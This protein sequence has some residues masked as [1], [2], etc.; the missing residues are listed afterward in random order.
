MAQGTD[1]LNERLDFIGIDKAARDRMRSLQPIIAAVI[2]DAMAKFYDKVRATPQTSQ[3]FSNEGQMRGAKARQESHWDVI[4]KAEYDASYVDGVN[5]VGRAHARLGLE[6]RWYIGGYALV[7]EDLIASIVRERWPSRFGRSGRAP[8]AAD[9]AVVVKAALLDMDYA[10][11]VYLETLANERKA[12]EEARLKTEEDQSVAMAAFGRAL[13]ALAE[14]D[15]QSR[16]PS[17]LPE[18]FRGMANDYN[19]AVQSLKGTISDARGAADQISIGADSIAQ[20]ADD[21]SHRTEQ[22][23]ASL[24]ESSAALH[25]LTE[26][27]KVTAASAQKAAY[28][29][30]K[31]KEE[32]DRSG[33]VVAKAVGAMGAIETSSDEIAKIIVVI[34]EIAFQTNLLALNAG[35]EAARAGDAGRGFAVVAQEVRELAQRCAAAAKEIKGL[36]TISSEQV[37]SGVT[38]VDSTGEA[39]NSIIHRISDINALVTE[40]ASAAREQSTGLAEVN[41]AINQMDEITQRNAAMVEET[42]AETHA[43]RGEAVRL[44]EQMAQFRIEA[45]RE[46]VAASRRPRSFAA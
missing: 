37:R 20:A 21:L 10:I 4:A 13:Q 43:L 27:V 9:I 8:L 34:D 41:S 35:V 6:P 19:N 31:A 23:A 28:V 15:L 7:I 29:V 3:F 18:N 11:S 12:A 38:L 26:S 17:D 16:M 5:K 39:L 32:A 40:I 36:I 22:Q 45:A 24:E 14:G 30:D 33:E 42:T 2:G 44:T 46:Q 1:A 25:Q